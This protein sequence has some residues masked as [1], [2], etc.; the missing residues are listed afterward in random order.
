MRRLA[1]LFHRLTTPVVPVADPVARRRAQLLLGITLV[2]IGLGVV[3][4]AASA[5][6]AAP[7]ERRS[8]LLGSAAT[9]AL[10]L[11]AYGVGHS[12]A[13]R[14]APYLLVILFTLNIAL[15]FS[16]APD[17][18]S[19]LSYLIVPLLFGSLFASLRFTFVLSLI[20]LALILLLPALQGRSLLAA[21]ETS[22]PF[23]VLTGGIILLVTWSRNVL[24][25]QQEAAI[26]QREAHLQSY[27]NNANDWIFT[28]DANGRLTSVNA[29]L[30]ETSG[31]SAAE[32]I[33][34]DPLAFVAVRNLD[35]ARRTLRRL[36]E[37]ETIRQ[38]ELPVRLRNGRTLWLEIRG[39]LFMENGRVVETL[40]IARDVTERHAAEAAERAQ[41]QLAESLTA[42]AAA[43]NSTL[44]VDQV[45]DQVL[46]SLDDVVPHD[47]SEI[48]LLADGIAATVR[49]RGYDRIGAAA[50]IE[51]QKFVVDETETLQHMIRTG[52]P[53]FIPDTQA[54][55]GWLHIPEFAW[56]RSYA[57]TPI[58]RQGQVLGFLQVASREPHRYAAADA[59]R[60]EAF[61]IHASNAIHNARLFAAETRRRVHAE[62]LREAAAVLNSSL[63]LD[64]VLQRILDQLTRAISCDTASLQQRIGNAMILRA[65]KGFTTPEK[66]HNL[67]IP[68]REQFPNAAIV[69]S[70]TPLAIADVRVDYPH[71]NDEAEHYQSHHIRSWLGVPLIVNDHVIGMFTLDRQVVHPYTA[72]EMSLA[73]AFA[74]HAAM[75]MHNA[76]LYEQ[77]ARY[78]ERL[79]TAVQQRTE[80]LQRTTEQIT[81]I[82]H[83]S[84]DA[85]FLIDSQDDIT[86]WNP[87]FEQLFK[88]LPTRHVAEL[89]D[90]LVGEPDRA[91]FRY[92]LERVRQTGRPA[93]LEFIAHAGSA[94]DFDADMAVFPVQ[95][96]S[97]VTPL[98]CSIRDISERMEVERLKDAFVSNV[99]H[100]LRTPIASLKL[101]HDLIRLN[102]TKQAIYMD[103]LEREIGR[104][105]VIVEGL[106]QLSRLD[107]GHVDWHMAPL[108]LNALSAQ[109][110]ADRQALAEAR[111]LQLSSRCAPNLPAVL[112]DAAMLGQVVDI[113]LTNAFNYT[114]AGG[115]VQLRTWQ[116]PQAGVTWAGISID[117]TGPGVPDAEHALVFERFYR[118]SSGQQSGAPGTGL[119]LA[120]AAEIVRH[121]GGRITLENTPAAGSGASFSIWLPA[122]TQKEIGDERLRDG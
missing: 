89:V 109:F 51:A 68:I 8:I 20:G 34:Q 95:P 54:F 111:Q 35:A 104:L 79:E 53:M 122:V 42:V 108:D 41:R 73:M 99:S 66:L 88:R 72:E 80:A 4:T 52:Q 46:D 30:C 9:I 40:H 107:Q 3:I 29:T 62:T 82:L 110:I 76:S 105:A 102:P 113:L 94:H 90:H 1:R 16:G 39:R 2:L 22:L 60:L 70:R 91:P 69:R 116:Q 26:R 75:A 103:R 77:L 12:R 7:G 36:L 14:V 23:Y 11:I 65:V 64:D 117:D 63:A 87:A 119:G 32:L 93:R 81:A 57:G 101:H 112:A 100:E 49:H 92:T 24:E 47:V 56:I 18:L 48:M 50:A 5:L 25:Q 59:R 74:T 115:H 31:Y 10:V 78:N 98:V 38:V 13:Y 43:I 17:R 37:G 85:V 45:L 28:L 86:I 15:L 118:G 106:L 84:P 120:I 27:I 71:F 61:A 33:G 121:H 114:P 83:N 44:D 55:P 19:F 67:T 97:P 21:A 96:N 6:V 58:Q